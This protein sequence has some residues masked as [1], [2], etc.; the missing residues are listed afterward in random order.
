MSFAMIQVFIMVAVVW[1]V[2]RSIS[3]AVK[4][5][6]KAILTLISAVSGQVDGGTPARQ[7][8]RVPETPR[9]S[10]TTKTKRLKKAT[11][12]QE[13]PVT[14]QDLSSVAVSASKSLSDMK[15]PSSAH[16]LR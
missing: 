9:R 14:V 15:L 10:I 6:L 4:T 7:K 5:C 11:S 3:D 13:Q 1:L 12:I 8:S 2:V 16:L